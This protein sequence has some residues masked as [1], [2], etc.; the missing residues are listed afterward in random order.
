M[1]HSSFKLIPGVDQN[2]TLALNEAAISDSQLIRFVPDRT[3]GGIV[4]KLGGWTKYF[5]GAMGST[6]RALWAWEDTN[7]NSYLAVGAEGIPAGGGGTLQ[8]IESG[9]SNDIT[10]QTALFNVPVSFSTTAGSNIVTV[11]HASSNISD[12]D[13][14]DIRTHVSVGGIILFGQYQCYSLS[15]NS[16]TIRPLNI[17]L[18]PYTATSTVSNGGAVPVFTLDSGSDFVNVTLANHNF[19]AGQAFP[20]L[21]ATS[22][23]GVTLYG[24]YQIRNIVDANNFVIAATTQ[25]STVAV[26][27]ASGTGTNATLTYSNAIT[28]INGATITVASVN[29][30]GYNG[31]HTINASSAGSLSYLSATTSA[32]VANG[33]I[34]GPFSI[35]E[36]SGLA[37]FLYQKG[38]GPLP[39]GTGYG[40]GPYGGGGYGT[41]I[42]P[43]AGTG[44]PINAE[45]WTL[46][47]WG[48]ILIA[49][50]INGPIYFWNPTLG[51]PVAQ[52]IPEAPVL[53]HGIFVAMPQRQIIA[54][55]TTF[56]GIHDPLLIRWCDVNNYNI[57]NALITNQAGS[58]RIP[59]GSKIIQCIQGPQQGLIWTDLSLWAMQYTGPEFIYQFNE[60]GT[61][62]G[63]IGRKAAG[64]M[65]GAVF[66]MGQSQFFKTMGSGVEPIR[67]PIWDVAFQD[68]DR[69]HVDNI[70]IATNSR[71]MEVSWFF[72]TIGS[73]GENTN[74]VKYNIIL[75]QWD[76]GT[77][78]RTAWINESV[79]GPPIAAASDQ[80]IYQHET[81]PDADGQAMQSYFQTGYFVLTE[82]TVKMFVDQ[83]W[84][85]MKWGYYNQSQGAN[86]L[87]TF[88]VTDYPG[89]TPIA[90]GP[91]TL[92]QAVNYITPRFRGRLVSIRIE[93]NDIGSWWRLGN[94][95]YRYQE[96]G[97]Y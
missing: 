53:N 24:S 89:E 25:A 19:I 60:I 45:D 16:Y 88:Y 74:Y 5:A 79:L 14:V 76:Y 77:L 58:Y 68:L 51:D 70:R 84:P 17:L 1:P 49:N 28:F 8:V 82:A 6:V 93:S 38:I 30:A 37:N 85:D 9:G 71:F 94:L 31:T 62:C 66:W 96:D 57:W 69:D 33:T 87:L 55:G 35:P 26:T 39:S 48:E 56:T 29:P 61:N 4:Q 47:N 64:S 21:V 95:R 34:S 72:P 50:P 40:V 15:A 52:V 20:V 73:N 44:T 32:Y 63:L 22:V 75:D 10:P 59:K 12:Y 7:S 67:C 91:F 78:N 42:P 18:E 27:G 86:V 81:S 3:L 41:G 97:R 2:K 65:N 80:H 46:D 83:V 11:T 23:A 90:Y 13:V 92:T 54:W 43:I 36:N